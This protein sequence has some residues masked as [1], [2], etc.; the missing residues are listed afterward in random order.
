MVDTNSDPTKV[1]FPIPSNDDASKSVAKVMDIVCASI[2]EGLAE[3]KE[4]K[5]T[6][7]NE[8]AKKKAAP[9][10]EK[11]DTSKATKVEIPSDAPAGEAPAKKA[12]AKEAPAKEAPAAEAAAKEAPAAEAAAKEAPAAEAAAKE[13]PAK[14]EKTDK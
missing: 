12:P 11:V 5:E 8:A 10:A 6:R 4:E 13:T 3:R 7:E 14:E 1:D 9:K 2:G